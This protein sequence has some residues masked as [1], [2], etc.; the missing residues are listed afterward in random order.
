MPRRNTSH[1]K[2]THWLRKKA[3]YHFW[4]NS[5][6][7]KSRCHWCKVEIVRLATL[8]PESVI[9]IKNGTIRYIDETGAE[10]VKEQATIDHVK[11]IYVGGTND[12]RNMVASCVN[13]NTK[14]A[15]AMDLKREKLPAAP[16]RNCGKRFSS[17]RRYCRPCQSAMAFGYGWN[18]S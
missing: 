3:Q 4:N 12:L 13:C 16:C 11:P 2:H 17:N 15:R 18:A 8:R 10:R 14:R 7:Q 6:K 1:S 9:E 5:F